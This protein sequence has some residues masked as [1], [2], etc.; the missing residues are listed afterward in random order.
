MYNFFK[1]SILLALSSSIFV[2]L[3]LDNGRWTDSGLY[4][5]QSIDRQFIFIF[6]FEISQH[7]IEI[8]FNSHHSIIRL[9]H[10]A[11]LKFTFTATFEM[12]NARTR[13]A[14]QWLSRSSRRSRCRCLRSAP[15][16]S[17]YFSSSTATNNTTDY[18][19]LSI[20][21][22]KQLAI[23]SLRQY[24]RQPSNQQQQ[25]ELVLQHILERTKQSESDFSAIQTSLIDAWTTHQSSIIRDMKEA[26][27]HETTTSNQQREQ[28]QQVLSS[29]HSMTNILESM[30]SPTPHHY[31][32][33]LKAWAN[34]C[35]IA[36]L[37]NA[38]KRPEIVGIPQ[39]TQL[40]LNQMATDNDNHISVEAY[41][42][43]IKAWAYSSE[44][45]R[46]AMAE[47]VFRKIQFP[48]GKS[49][50][51]IMR[52]HAWSNEDRSAFQ[53]TG[54]FMR[55]MRLL[56]A[57]R[58]DMEPSSIDDYHLL[59]NAWTQAGDKNSSSKVYS[60]LQIMQN[61]FDRGHT[62]IRADLQCY[63]DALIT[64]SRRQNVEDVGN[65][66]DETLKEM[67]DQMIFPD[68]KCYSSAILAWKHVAMSR[69]CLYPEHAIRR[70]QELLQEMT[71]A[72]HRTT[73]VLIQ[74]TTQDYNN[75]LQA[76]TL[77][78][79]PQT[80]LHA[81]DLFKALKDDASS[82]GGPDAPSYKYLLG[83]LKNSRSPMK[84]S[85]ASQLL[86]EIKDKYTTDENWSSSE[87]AKESTMDAFTAFVRVCGSTGNT[88]KTSP[89]LSRQD[90][91]KMMTVALQVLTDAKQL[92]LTLNSDTYTAL[93]EA[94]DSLLSVNE[95]ERESVLSNVFLRACEEGFVNQG[96]LESFKS[97]ASAH[98]FANLVVSNSIPMEDIKIVPESWTR[99]VKGNREG[100]QVMPLSIHGNFTFTKR[101][102]E[103]RMRK[104]RQRKNQKFLRGG[105]LK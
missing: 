12:S 32:A 82:T 5:N 16:A 54:H 61:A 75:V 6:S 55:M 51:L 79:N 46:G 94:C 58:E 97:A 69:D 98:L 62:N 23:Q 85:I 93:V 53:A 83:I 11:K 99:N 47:Q 28:L 88:S 18:S 77:S 70:T 3:K 24:Q 38:S 59:C 35:K 26:Q 65:L 90:R 50:R 86:Q 34:T 45:L 22:L 72:Y 30:E 60:V 105:R 2:P 36:K 40:I 44:Y 96:L 1:H 14:L 25:H 29:T 4:W 87:L 56:E 80:L 68:T 43:V 104:L 100:R 66:A 52:A 17:K 8:Q 39:R 33:I 78:K 84:H 20:N 10:Q 95:K 101:A 41:N 13:S 74:P 19:N 37:I 76:M 67:K 81:Q 31:V 57:G 63:R 9:N 103:Y 15:T 64:M 102:A 27:S 73:E 89:N 21:E 7:S 42:E 92:G 49:L 71:E 91:T 48:T